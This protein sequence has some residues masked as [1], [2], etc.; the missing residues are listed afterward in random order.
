[1]AEVVLKTPDAPMTFKQGIMI[2]RLGGG[3]VRP[4][5]LTMQQASDRI[6]SLL[7]ANPDKKPT[8]AG[9]KAPA[10]KSA[11]YHPFAE[12]LEKATEAA[13]KAT[14]AWIKQAQ[15]VYRVVQHANPLDDKS[16]VVK[17]FGTMLD[18]C[19]IAYIDIVDKRTKFARWYMENTKNGD[20]VRLNF[21]HRFRQEMGL[22]EAAHGAIMRV[23]MEAGITGVRSHI[24]I[25]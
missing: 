9:K 17:D 4:E 25:D 24:R 14:E 11:N 3:D 21:K 1:M 23:F 19:C 6:K 10:K 12:A 13:D 7:E 15:P 8:K 22:H 20:F 18:V 2:R 16:P 5:K